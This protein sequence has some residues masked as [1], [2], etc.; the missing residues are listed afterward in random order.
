MEETKKILA[1]R[2]PIEMINEFNR[3]KGSKTYHLKKGP[4]FCLKVLKRGD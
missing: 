4:R 1:G 2:M 3:L